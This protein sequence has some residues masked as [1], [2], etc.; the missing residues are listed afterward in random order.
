M[1]VFFKNEFVNMF[2]KMAR[3]EQNRAKP[4]VV[5]V[6]DNLKLVPNPHVFQTLP[7]QI[8]MDTRSKLERHLKKRNIKLDPD[9]VVFSLVDSG[10]VI[11]FAVNTNNLSILEIWSIK[12]IK[13]LKS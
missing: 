10:F 2:N 7:Y 1:Q 9:D 5:Q 11:L 13:H 8:S 3:D 12:S 4:F 6:W